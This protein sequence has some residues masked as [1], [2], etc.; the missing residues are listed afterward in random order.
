MNL[1]ENGQKA[2]EQGEDGPRGMPKRL[3]K[4]APIGAMPTLTADQLEEKQI[5]AENKRKRVC[6]LQRSVNTLY[7]KCLATELSTMDDQHFI[8]NLYSRWFYRNFTSFTA[9]L[10]SKL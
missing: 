2:I 5:K 9:H 10:F 8:K 3:K 1:D 4:L 6:S 7:Q